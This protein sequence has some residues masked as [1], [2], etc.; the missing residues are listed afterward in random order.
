MADEE[1]DVELNGEN[2]EE[3][4][5]VEAVAPADNLDIPKDTSRGTTKKLTNIGIAVLVY[6]MCA[7]Q[8]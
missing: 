7:A 3:E 8:V 4:V 5:A 1:L 6:V 2:A